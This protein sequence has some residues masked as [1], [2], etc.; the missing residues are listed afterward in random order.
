MFGLTNFSINIFTLPP[1]E[2]SAKRYWHK[3]QGEFLYV[4]AGTVTLVSNADETPVNAVLCIDFKAAV[5]DVHM[6]E[7]KSTGVVT[8]LCVGD[9]SNPEHGT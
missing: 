8:Y 1:G 3:T 9:R 7:N 4:I 5:A 6:L 2:W